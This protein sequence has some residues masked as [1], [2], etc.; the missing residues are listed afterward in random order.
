[1]LTLKCSTSNLLCSQLE[2][3]ADTDILLKLFLLKFQELYQVNTEKGDLTLQKKKSYLLLTV[4]RHL[5]AVLLKHI[6][7]SYFTLLLFRRRQVL[8]FLHGPAC[9]WLPDLSRAAL[10]TYA[11]VFIAQAVVYSSVK[12]PILFICRTAYSYSLYFP[13][14]G[15][16]SA[17][18][19]FLPP[20]KSSI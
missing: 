7:T 16:R 8:G 15:S 1:M 19:P 12:N 11:Q 10:R 17:L 6:L 13:S 2:V 14:I 5:K 4:W 18:S 20:M 3:H 9:P